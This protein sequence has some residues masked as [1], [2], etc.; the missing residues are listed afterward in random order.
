MFLRIIEGLTWLLH[1]ITTKPKP[2][3]VESLSIVPFFMR[4]NIEVCHRQCL[5]NS[6]T[7]FEYKTRSWP[8]HLVCETRHGAAVD[9]GG[10]G[11]SV[12][13]REGSA[14]RSW[15]QSASRDVW[16][17]NTTTSSPSA[18]TPVTVDMY[19]GGEPSRWRHCSTCGT[20]T[21]KSRT[22]LVADNGIHEAPYIWPA[23]TFWILYIINKYL[24]IYIDK[25]FPE[26]NKKGFKKNFIL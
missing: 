6:E 20:T 19:C 25:Y 5:T 15:K 16:L 24:F 4:E 21:I 17:A 14:T 18:V 11:G 7:D 13:G 23:Y 9:C 22:S 26:E 8:T 10:R 3:A 12:G 2:A 1:N